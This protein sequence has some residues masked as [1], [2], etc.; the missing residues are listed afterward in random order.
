MGYFQVRY[1]CRVVIYN[2]IAFCELWREK[3]NSTGS[4]WAARWA[5]RSA[6]SAAILAVIEFRFAEICRPEPGI[7]FDVSHS[8]K[9]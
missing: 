2:F 3:F 5:A 7:N 9:T 4:S 1:D 8:G 6:S